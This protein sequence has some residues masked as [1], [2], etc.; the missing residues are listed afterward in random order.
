MLPTIQARIVPNFHRIHEE[1][2]GQL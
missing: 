2:S 1:Y